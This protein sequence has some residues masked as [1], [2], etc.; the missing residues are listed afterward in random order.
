MPLPTALVAEDLILH[1]TI[2]VVL[3]SSQI[4]VISLS[5]LWV[6]FAKVFYILGIYRH[7]TY[8][9]CGSYLF[10]IYK[11]TPICREKGSSLTVVIHLFCFVHIHQSM[12]SCS[13][14]SGAFHTAPLQS[15]AIFCYIC[16]L[17]TTFFYLLPHT[18]AL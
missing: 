4:V 1:E 9:L 2:P 5:V 10:K 3:C 16:S 13:S 6:S 15:I 14:V 11:V 17:W 8:S 12:H 18:F 7:G